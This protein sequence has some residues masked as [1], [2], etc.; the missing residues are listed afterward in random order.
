[1][2]ALVNLVENAAK[3]SAAGAAIRLQ[4]ERPWP[5]VRISV[6]DAGPAIPDEDLPRLFEKFYRGSTG[7]GTKGTGLGLAIVEKMVELCGGKASVEATSSGNR[8]AI[9]LPAAA[10][11]SL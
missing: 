11:P 8:F 3:F 7:A 5:V 2:Q 4:V 9:E 10:A 1:M 6:I